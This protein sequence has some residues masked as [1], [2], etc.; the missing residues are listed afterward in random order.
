MIPKLESAQYVLDYTIHIKF[1]DG[2][3][4][5]ADL[6][7]ELWG[8]VFESL[9]DPEEFRR[10][11]LDKELNTVSWASGADLAPEFLYDMAAQQ[12]ARL[13]ISKEV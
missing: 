5:D 8:E 9:N 10:F 6:R 4:A 3:E 13:G 2:T 12:A 11:Q 1:A 7:N